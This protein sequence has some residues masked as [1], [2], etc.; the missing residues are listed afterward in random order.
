MK[1]TNANALRAHY[2][3]LLLDFLTTSEDTGMVTSNCF[4]FPVTSPDGEEG[5]A[6]VTVKITK[7]SGDDGY[8]KRDEYRQKCEERKARQE[9]KARKDA[10]RAQKK[11]DK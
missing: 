1:L 8:L 4:N 3:D 2:I 5:W 11:E 6:E 7:E 9:E 10:E